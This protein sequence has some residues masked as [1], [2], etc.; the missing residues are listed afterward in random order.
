MTKIKTNDNRKTT[1]PTFKDIKAGVMFTETDCEIIYIKTAVLKNEEDSTTT[2]AIDLEGDTH[3]FDAS[4]EIWL[5]REVEV[6]IKG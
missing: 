1:N 6:T 2:N 3:W 5:I 4:D